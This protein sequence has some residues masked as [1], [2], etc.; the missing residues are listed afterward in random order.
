MKGHGVKDGLTHG[1]K[2]VFKDKEANSEGGY[3][4]GRVGGW[5]DDRLTYM[6]YKY[7]D[8]TMQCVS[9]MVR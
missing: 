8:E 4:K 3:M 7:Q 5:D 2:L 1:A 6:K 9:D